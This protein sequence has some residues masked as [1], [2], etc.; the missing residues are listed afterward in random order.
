MVDGVK[1]FHLTAEV[2]K[3]EFLPASPMWSARVADVW[4]FNGGMPGP[5]IEVNEGDRLRIVFHNNLPEGITIH[6]RGVELPIEMDGMPF[7]S[8][9][10]RCS[11]KMGCQ[12]RRKSGD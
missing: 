11:R 8:Q 2:V 3:R 4:G 1:V 9:P 10:I 7:I 12:A 5:I 6:R